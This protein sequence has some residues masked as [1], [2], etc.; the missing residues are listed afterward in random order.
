MG[1]GGG[2]SSGI[3]S[4]VLAKRQALAKA[5]AAGLIGN[6]AMV[7]GNQAVRGGGSP[8]IERLNFASRYGALPWSIAPLAKR[9]DAQLG[10]RDAADRP[11]SSGEL[12]QEISGGSRNLVA[13]AVADTGDGLQNLSGHDVTYSVS[14]GRALEE[15][16]TRQARLPPV[17]G[18][19]FDA[20]VTPAWPGL[21]QPV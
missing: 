8:D 14:F 1:A 15:Y 13:S 19:A 6:A 7:G 21:K 2:A 11:G 16:F 17:G 9:W 3:T 5:R 18:P 4:A 12:G 20:R 10:A